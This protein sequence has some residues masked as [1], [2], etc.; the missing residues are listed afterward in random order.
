MSSG[1]R[2]QL[3][4]NLA[5]LPAAVHIAEVAPA[6]GSS[7]PNGEELY[8]KN[9]GAC[10]QQGGAGIPGAF[11]PLDKSPYVTG[12]NVERL[13]AIMV[14]GLSG[15]IDVLGT[16]YNSAMAPLGASLNDEQ[17][18]AIATYIRT[19]WSNEAG[20]IEASVFADVRA[21]YGTRAMFTIAEL[22][23]EKPS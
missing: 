5:S 22:G 8:V 10:H 3:E 16:T 13:A 18:A 9:C 1:A 23:E 11:P 7:G 17:L 6:D 19:A 2:S 4:P 15:P 12:D 14:Y 20:A 21:K